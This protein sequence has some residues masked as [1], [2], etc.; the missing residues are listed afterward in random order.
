MLKRVVLSAVLCGFVAQP[1]LAAACYTT[2]EARAATV[3]QLQTEL[4][5]AALKCQ[6]HPDGL[7][8]HYNAF[9]NKFAP[10][11]SD[12]A[13]VLRGHFSRAYG[14]DHARRFDAF[15]TTLANEASIKSIQTV[16][17]CSSMTPLFQ[18]VMTVRS[19]E[20]EDFAQKAVQSS[21]QSC[22]G[23]IETAE[24]VKPAKVA[25]IAARTEKQ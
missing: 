21:A 3:R 6:G 7:A 14:R 16:N 9:V 24:T 12:N 18:T 5:V 22:A 17:Y 2:V 10:N 13:K 8:A 15:I 20:L 25:K 11:L 1:A 19:H 23:K 4:M